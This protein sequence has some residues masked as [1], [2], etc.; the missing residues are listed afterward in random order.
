MG[1]NYYLYKK[2]KY[3]EGKHP[4]SHAGFDWCE[5]GCCDSD[6]F[7]AHVQ[8]LKNGYVWHGKYYPTIKDLNRDYYEKYHIG[9]ASYGWAFCLALY[10]KNGLSSL[11]DYSKA[12]D[13]ELNVIVD[14]SGKPVSK[15]QRLEII[16]QGYPHEGIL[17]RHTQAL[18]D[19]YN[20]ID[21]ENMHYDTVI[22]GND[23][24]TECIFC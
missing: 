15:K 20:I 5:W 12:F 1:T 10:P 9:K 6:D 16:T 19:Q 21:I 2:A 4:G 17:E 14:E 24:N 18:A 22:S 7:S 23:A 3:E 13:D 8:K 11:E